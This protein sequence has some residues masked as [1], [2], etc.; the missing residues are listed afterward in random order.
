MTH[1][2]QPKNPADGASRVTRLSCG[3][4]RTHC[5]AAWMR[6]SISTLSSAFQGRVYDPC[7][8]SSGMFMQ[9]L[10]FIHAR[11]GFLI[12]GSSPRWWC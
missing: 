6:L 11:A 3:R 7:C 5:G 2:Q 12:A 8:G 9:S 10:E 4:W 1:Q